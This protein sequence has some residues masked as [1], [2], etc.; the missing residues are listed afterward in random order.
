MGRAG[1]TLSNWYYCLSTGGRTVFKCSSINLGSAANIVGDFTGDGTSDV[2]SY[3]QR[4]SFDNLKSRELQSIVTGTGSRIAVSYGNSSENYKVSPISKLPFSVRVVKTVSI[5]DQWDNT[6]ATCATGRD[7]LTSYTYYGGYY[8]TSQREFRGFGKV[9]VTTPTGPN[10]ENSTETTLFHQGDSV[11]NREAVDAYLA[12]RPQQTIVATNNAGGAVAKITTTYTYQ[13]PTSVPFFTPVTSIQKT[14]AY[15][16]TDIITTRQ[17]MAYADGYGNVTS[18]TD[19]GDTSISTDDRLPASEAVYTGSAPNSASKIAETTFYYGNATNCTTAATSQSPTLGY[20][21]QRIS[22]KLLPG[23]TTVDQV[24]GHDAVGNIICNKDPRGNVSTVTYDTNATFP[25]TFTNPLNQTV[26]QYY[27]VNGVAA[28]NGWIG[29]LKSVSDPNGAVTRNVYDALGR[30]SLQYSPLSTSVP[31]V[32]YGYPTLA[33]FGAVGTQKITRTLTGDYSNSPAANQTYYS[34]FDGFGRVIKSVQQPN[35]LTGSMPNII[36]EN[37]FDVRGQLY[38]TSLPYYAGSAVYWTT[39]KRDGFGRV[40]QANNADGTQSLQCQDGR[41]TGAVAPY[42]TGIDGGQRKRFTR[43]GRGRLIKVEEYNSTVTS[44]STSIGT[45]YATTSYVYDAMD[46]L[47][48]LTDARGNVTS[49]VYDG[50]GRKTSMND[51]DMGAWSYVYDA[52]GN[53]TQ[54]ADAKS[55]SIYYQY[56]ALNRI[57]QKDYGTSKAL[58][59]GDIVYSYDNY[60]ALSGYDPSNTRPAAPSGSAPVGRLT[61]VKDLAGI[62]ASYY[63]LAG[64]TLQSDQRVDGLVFNRVEL[65]RP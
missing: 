62:T 29:Q 54:Q 50:L 21:L 56:D 46:R 51:P 25:L 16:N 60:T 45:P 43:D 10:A 22:R 13:P 15:A 24:M 58:G 32:A 3:N 47:T 11:G 49:I 20:K 2:L 28:D 19:Y 42:K 64:N 17:D 23:S 6:A 7:A 48:Q 31:S 30:I 40:Y 9:V 55:Q 63:D 34:Y 27:G 4:T 37:T 59:S 36:Q 65:R 41:V 38:R 1:D 14:A 52:N 18:V 35:N 26:L 61:S 44:C 57:R 53:L 39:F 12:G 8:S 33:E 5:C